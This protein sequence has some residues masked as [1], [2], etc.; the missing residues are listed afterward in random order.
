MWW[1]L[2]VSAREQNQHRGMEDFSSATAL[3]PAHTR[4][5]P[6]SVLHRAAGLTSS[7]ALP[8]TLGPE[9]RDRAATSSHSSR[10][11]SATAA[12]DCLCSHKE[13]R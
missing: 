4:L 10:H 7:A 5:L 12:R 6:S 8:V 2:P 1:V 9:L 13:A 11:D 3:I